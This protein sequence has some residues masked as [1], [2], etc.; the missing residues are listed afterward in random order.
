MISRSQVLCAQADA[1]LDLADAAASGCVFDDGFLLDVPLN[2]EKIQFYLQ[3]RKPGVVLTKLR[4]PSV[5]TTGLVEAE[6]VLE[7][8]IGTLIWRTTTS[9]VW[10]LP[11]M[12]KWTHI[13]FCVSGP[14]LT[15]DGQVIEPKTL[16]EPHPLVTMP[17]RKTSQTWTTWAVGPIDGVGASDASIG[18]EI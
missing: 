8:G 10:Q 1:V 18:A 6:G 13:A 2:A 17:V 16:R 9:V 7:T 11:L 14:T 5:T 12:T 3:A 15:V 4:P